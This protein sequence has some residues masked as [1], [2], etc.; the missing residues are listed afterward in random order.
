MHRFWCHIADRGCSK[1]EEKTVSLRFRDRSAFDERNMAC[2][3]LGALNKRSN[4]DDRGVKIVDK[5]KMA[6]FACRSAM[7]YTT[8]ALKNHIRCVCLLSLRSYVVHY[9]SAPDSLL[10]HFTTFHLTIVIAIKGCLLLRSLVPFRWLCPRTLYIPRA[11]L[12]LLLH[13]RRLER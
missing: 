3:L 1:F 9:L 8:A 11:L 12:H 6:V 7:Q 13:R 10:F 2:A 4:F 5:G